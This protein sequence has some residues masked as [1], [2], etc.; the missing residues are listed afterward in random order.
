MTVNEIYKGPCREELMT[1]TPT[2]TPTPKL[3]PQHLIP[4]QLYY[5][6]PGYVS[7]ILQNEVPRS[8]GM[9]KPSQWQ[10]LNLYGLG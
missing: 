7:I 3:K 5:T 10:H 9:I 4:L 1:P 6:M 2:R 8:T